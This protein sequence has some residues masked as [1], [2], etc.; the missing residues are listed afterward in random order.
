MSEAITLL[1]TRAF[2]VVVLAE[3]HGDVVKAFD[4]SLLCEVKVPAIRLRFARERC[5][6]VVLGLAALKRHV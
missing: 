5:L 2:D 6:Q 1:G 3:H 4:I